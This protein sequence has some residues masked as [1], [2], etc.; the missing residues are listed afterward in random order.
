MNDDCG[1]GL[2]YTA[3]LGKCIVSQFH[4]SEQF[5]FTIVRGIKYAHTSRTMNI[6]SALFIFR[7]DFVY[8]VPR[9]MCKSIHI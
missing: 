7:C 9:I 8:K 1:G 6:Q 5:L 3:M 4:R 2:L